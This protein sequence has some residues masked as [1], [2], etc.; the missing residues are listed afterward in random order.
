LDKDLS[1]F[2]DQWF[3]QAGCPDIS[4]QFSQREDSL[5]VTARQQQKQEPY[6]LTGEIL[7]RGKQ[8]ETLRRTVTLTD[9]ETKLEFGIEFPVQEVLFD[10]DGRLLTKATTS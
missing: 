4:V 1:W 6:R 10:P 2:F 8:G 9:R 5:T 7:I 3:F